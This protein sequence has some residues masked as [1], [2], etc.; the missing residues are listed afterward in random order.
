VHDDR[1]LVRATSEL[2]DPSRAHDRPQIEHG[3]AD[4]FLFRLGR[5]Q[6][7]SRTSAPTHHDA[8]VP[9]RRRLALPNGITNSC[10][11]TRPFVGL[12]V[13]MLARGHHGVVAA[14][15]GPQQ[16]GRVDRVRRKR[17]AN[18]G[19]CAKMLSRLA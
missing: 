2:I 14:D 13:E 1:R 19:Q 4:A 5:R 8:S 15:G 6:R 3:D 18:P 10:R 12:A 16:A 11:D 17:D 7:R 9:S